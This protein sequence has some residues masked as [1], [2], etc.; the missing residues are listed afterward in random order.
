MRLTLHMYP[1][2]THQWDS[3]RRAPS[4]T[5]FRGSSTRMRVSRRA[6]QLTLFK[7]KGLDAKPK[8]LWKT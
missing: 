4:Y 2:A 8:G 6:Q 5:R 7:S 1:G 3:S